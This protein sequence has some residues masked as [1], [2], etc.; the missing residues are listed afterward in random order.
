VR[1][2]IREDYQRRG[3]Q[4]DS[5]DLLPSQPESNDADTYG[6]LRTAAHK[7]PRDWLEPETLSRAWRKAVEHPRNRLLIVALWSWITAHLF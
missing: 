5:S 2:V 1:N 4:A 3:A 6:W 7:A